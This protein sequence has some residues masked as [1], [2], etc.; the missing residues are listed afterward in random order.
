MFMHFIIKVKQVYRNLADGEMAFKLLFMGYFK[1]EFT[2][3]MLFFFFFF[4]FV[5]YVYLVNILVS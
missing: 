2:C 1:L 3:L 5:R 4:F